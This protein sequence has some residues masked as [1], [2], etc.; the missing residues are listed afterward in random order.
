MTTRARKNPYG[1]PAGDVVV[2]DVGAGRFTHALN[3]E[4]GVH[5]CRSGI[6]A[7]RGGKSGA[8]PEVSKSR[9][10]FITCYRCQKLLSI[11]ERAD[12]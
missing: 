6:N 7:G 12:T 11:N 5:L 9:S 2:V 4:T 10:K 1:R 8:R 3:P